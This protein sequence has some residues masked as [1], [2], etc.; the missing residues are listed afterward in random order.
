MRTALQR[1]AF[2]TSRLQDY[3]SESELTQQMGYVPRMWPLVLLKELMDNGLDACEGAGVPPK[4]VISIEDNGFT[5]T[6]N[7]PGLSAEIIE[8]ALDYTVRVSDKRH[9]V[10]PTRGQLGNALKLVFAAA[11]V[12]TGTGHVEIQ[13]HG[14]CHVIDVHLD[15]LKQEPKITHSIRDGS[16]V[17]IGTSVRVGWAGLAS[18]RTTSKTLD[19]YDDTFPVCARA[20]VSAFSAF[21]PH[22]NFTIAPS[23][24][25]RSS[26]NG[27]WRK[28]L[29]TDPTSPHWYTPE[30][31]RDLIAAYVNHDGE[32]KTVRGFLKEFAGLSRSQTQQEVFQAAKLSGPNLA[33]MVNSA[34]TDLDSAKVESLLAAMKVSRPIKPAQLGGIIGEKHLFDSLAAHGA[35]NP[36]TFRYKKFAFIDDDNGLPTITE[37]AFG[38][39]PKCAHAQFA[40]GLNHSVA[41]EEFSQT[42][43]DTLNSLHVEGDDSV[44]LIAHVVCPHF[45]FSGH[46]KGR[47]AA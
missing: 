5:V 43:T 28:W 1:T 9:Y 16:N 44:V 33:D 11:Y 27:T 20:L 17:Q 39:A 46:G 45:Q 21:N 19:L 30:Q 40:L 37:I 31:L 47:I 34:G 42:L 2:T 15:R 32:A 24:T 4:I 25:F 18:Y 8:R 29:P 3:F 35:E 38:I 12:A 23:T 41:L 14:K 7:G 26:L 36:K 10:A 6:D 22:A 13:A